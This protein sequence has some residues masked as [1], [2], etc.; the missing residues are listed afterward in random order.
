MAEDTL[1]CD[2]VRSS[3]RPSAATPVSGAPRIGSTPAA[4]R[5]SLRARRRSQVAQ[6]DAQP[7]TAEPVQRGEQV[8]QRMRT[9][10]VPG[11]RHV[12]TKVDPPA[13]L[14]EDDTST[15]IEQAACALGGMPTTVRQ[16]DMEIDTFSE[17]DGARC[18]AAWVRLWPSWLCSIAC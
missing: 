15:R 2:E 1:S 13:A 7:L 11:V 6:G 18:G 14:D 4:W 8:L 9:V 16:S 12:A 3:T 17:P 5:R 10:Q